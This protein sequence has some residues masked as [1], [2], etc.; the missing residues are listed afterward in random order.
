M[1]VKEKGGFKIIG[2]VKNHGIIY[3]RVLKN[4]KILYM[5]EE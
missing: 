5:V 3:F 1:K 2:N 4:Y